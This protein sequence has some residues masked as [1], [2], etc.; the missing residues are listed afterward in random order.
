MLGIIY[1]YVY[2]MLPYFKICSSVKT[3]YQLDSKDCGMSLRLAF[4]P[5]FCIKSK[6]T[7]ALKCAFG[8]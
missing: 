3:N 4:L 8:N 2:G 6:V 7:I 5:L 1:L